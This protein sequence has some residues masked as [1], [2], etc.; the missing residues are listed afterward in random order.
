MIGRGYTPNQGST[1]LYHL[2]NE[3]D[4][5]NRSLSQYNQAV[6]ALLRYGVPVKIEARQ[7]TETVH[8][9]DW[10]HPQRNDFWI[11]EEVTLKGNHERRPDIVLYV[12]GIAVAVLEL[13]NSRVSISDGIRQNLSNQRPEFNMRTGYIN[14]R[15]PI[16]ISAQKRTQRLLSEFLRATL[17]SSTSHLSVA[18]KYGTIKK[19]LC[20][21]TRSFNPWVRPRCLLKR[22]CIRIDRDE[23]SYLRLHLFRHAL[24][25]L[26][27]PV[28]LTARVT[29]SVSC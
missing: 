11:A 23:S 28:R 7:L 29:L 21:L 4:N 9:I 24:C 17:F 6:Y 22:L 13:K 15:H 27:S 18:A 26:P 2:R 16:V 10:Q 14:G 8:L 19:H 5:P 1:A 3:A 20:A 12:N 25:P